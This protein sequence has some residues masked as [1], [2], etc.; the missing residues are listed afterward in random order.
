MTYD[1]ILAL[2]LYAFATSITPGP[3][4]L[5]L[6]ASGANFGVRKT[7]P[8]LTGVSLGFMLM[9][10]IIGLGLVRLFEAYPVILEGLQIVCFL[11]LLYLAWRIATASTPK[12]EGSRRSK[13]LTFFE[14]VIFQWINPKAIAMA[15][16]TITAYTHEQTL[17][18]ILTSIT[19]FG[20][21]NLPACGMWV[22]LGQR[23]R[24]WLKGERTLLFFNLTM[25]SLL[26]LSMLPM[27]LSFGAK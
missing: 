7:M 4:N 27:L 12:T 2:A 16:T 3:N 23:L 22:L 1:S 6:M 20:L 10:L 19:L 17:L 21:V 9:T 8:H 25:A 14:A 26:I 11:F 18:A 24:M 5:M 15:L 13:P